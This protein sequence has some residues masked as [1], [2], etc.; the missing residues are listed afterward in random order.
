MLNFRNARP[1][2]AAK[3]APVA[4]QSG[5]IQ[6]GVTLVVAS[7]VSLL[8]LTGALSAAW[9]NWQRARAEL[10]DTAQSYVGILAPSLAESVVRADKESAQR[11]V[12]GL[13]SDEGFAAA[14]VTSEGDAVLAS[15]QHAGR[16]PIR[17]AD[18]RGL[19]AARGEIFDANRHVDI[20]IPHGF[21]IVEPLQAQNVGPKG[22]LIVRFSYDQTDARAWRD[23]FYLFAGGLLI[24]ATLAVLLHQLIGRAIAP[25]NSLT[26]AMRAL[27]SGTLDIRVK[28]LKRKDEVGELA[29]AIA[30]FREGLVDRQTLLVAAEERRQDE[31][32]RR[33]AI[34]AMIGEFRS[35]IR[36]ALHQVGSHTE[37]MIIAADSLSSIATQSHARAE[38]ASRASAEA[39]GNVATVARASE[40][41]Y[42]SISEIETQIGRARRHVQHAAQTTISTSETIGGLAEKANS[43]GEI[44]GLIQAIAAQ[45]NLLAL[46]ATIEAARAGAAGRGF[47]VVAQEV[48]ALAGQTAHATE[49]IAEHVTAIQ[50][51]TGEAVGAISNIATTMKEAETFTTSIA[52]A[53]EEQAA[54]TNEISRSV[55]EAARGTQSMSFDMDGLKASVGETDQSAAQVHQAAS[56][57]AE[58]ARD[59]NLTIED[60]LKRVAAA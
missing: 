45:T 18:I 57:V 58:Q 3:L 22:F 38:N 55:G 16:Q 9:Y 50:S 53:V 17:V 31:D 32:G 19:M 2:S 26:E 15:A 41:L 20:A 11:L 8:V 43:I 47:A 25:I 48:K 60:F 51:A 28:G 33:V 37:Q 27:V 42:H 39:S 30:F 24:I 4:G 54:A 14:A 29:R 46:N 59:L 10:M 36:G 49:R 56:D 40:E 1:A 34:E 21:V 6:N 5:S 23:L 35:S 7:I 13:L 52:V 12:S 44:V